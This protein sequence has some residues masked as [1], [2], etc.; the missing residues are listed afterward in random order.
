MASTQAIDVLLEKLSK[1][2][3][4]SA[5][6]H[7]QV[8]DGLQSL[9]LQL[10]A[11]EDFN[12]RYV[13]LQLQRIG[14][15]LGQDLNVFQ[16][17]AESERPL[18]VDELSSE[19]SAEPPLLLGQIRETSL[20]TYAA[21]NAT[22]TL[23]QPKYRGFVY[24][25]FHTVGNITQ[26]FPDALAEAN[27]RDVEQVAETAFKKAFSTDVSGF[28]WLR[29][30]PRHWEALQQAMSVAP[31]ARVPWY[32]VFPFE[33]E[34][35]AASPDVPALVDI[36]GGFGHQCAALAAAFPALRGRLVLQD[37]PQT[38]AIA[39]PL[40]GVRAMEH[41]FFKPQPVRG[42]RFYYLRN[43]LH[44]WPHDK[45]VA[46]LSRV[47]EALGTESQVLIDEIVVPN[48]GAHWHATCMDLLMMTA[49]GAQERTVD[50]WHALLDDA[51]LR[52]VKIHNYLPR[53]EDSIIQAVAK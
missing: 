32:S 49:V 40:D 30:Q 36:G 20:D 50:E 1:V 8:L 9:Q 37:M 3:S 16:T 53:H 24:H 29:A 46:I 10:E 18:T 11:P 28:E 51:G 22:K 27:F 43:V 13:N 7:S 33:A 21:S 6:A 4:Q 45:A 31:Q 47:R 17:L 39:P 41:D 5:E 2:A 52:I 15:Q 12:L 42:V 48:S 26:A 25:N 14:A 44:D 23:A 38:L 19:S 34:L 35:G